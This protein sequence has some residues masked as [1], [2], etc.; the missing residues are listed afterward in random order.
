L[1]LCT[2]YNY[3]HTLTRNSMFNSIMSTDCHLC[4]PCSYHSS[5]LYIAS[6]TLTTN[7]NVPHKTLSVSIISRWSAIQKG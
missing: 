3:I 2:K 1:D 7:S 6:A 4:I 5:R